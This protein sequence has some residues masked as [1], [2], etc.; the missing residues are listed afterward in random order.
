MKRKRHTEEQIIAILKEHE[1]GKKTADLCRRY[2]IS[3][4]SFYNWSPAQTARGST[5]SAAVSVRGTDIA[6]ASPA[7]ARRRQYRARQRAGTAVY[8]VELD[9]QVLSWLISL[10]WL[11][12]VE[13][14]GPKLPPQLPG[15]WGDGHINC[16]SKQF[17]MVVR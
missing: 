9:G 10:G 1:A 7:A 12:E 11:L 15:Q 14:D 17:W 5:T 6:S 2:G 8:P 16:Q 4:A 3:E 13:A